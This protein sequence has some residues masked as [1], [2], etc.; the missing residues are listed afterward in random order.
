MDIEQ[1]RNY[2]MARKGA[3]EDFAFGED[4]LLFRVCNKIFACL[5]LTRPDRVTLKCDPER[6]L[7]LREHY[8]GI[9]GAWHWNKRYWNEVHFDSDVPDALILEL[10]DHSLAEVLR[11]LPK[12]TQAAYEA[13]L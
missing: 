5:D 10:V 9:E 3:T 12:K 7:E 13:D 4:T 2:C 11:K 8:E 1:I 6:A